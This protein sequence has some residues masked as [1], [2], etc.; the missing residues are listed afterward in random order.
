MSR[1]MYFQASK[2]YMKSMPIV[3]THLQV[4]V[5]SIRLLNC[6]CSESAYMCSNEILANFKCIALIIFVY[7]HTRATFR[8]VYLFIYTTRIDTCI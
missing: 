4:C 7:G 3:R 1:G 5:N 6:I 8:V 2:L